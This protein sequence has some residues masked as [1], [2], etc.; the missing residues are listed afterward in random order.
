MSMRSGTRKS[1]D[2]KIFKKTAVKSKKINIK[3]RGYRGGIAL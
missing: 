2:K 1:I 3:P